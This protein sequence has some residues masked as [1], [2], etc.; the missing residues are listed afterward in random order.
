MKVPLNDDERGALTSFVFNLGAGNLASS[1]LLKLLNSGDR[2]GAGIQFG[3][4]VYA[5]V[6]GV[7][8]RLPGL[9]ARRAAEEALFVGQTVQAQAVAAPEGPEESRIKR[10]QRIVGA[11]PNGVYD[12]V[13]QAAV[14]LWQAA[15]HLH[16]DGIVGP[17]TARAMGIA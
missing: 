11:P 1:T 16:A 9:V 15:N 6:N 2:G 13:T 12:P 8:T 14:T 7:R 10:I 3:R 17:I 5:T 4:W